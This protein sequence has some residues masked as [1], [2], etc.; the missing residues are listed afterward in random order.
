MPR[1]ARDTAAF[2]LIELMIV[3]AILG[4]LASVAIPSFNSYTRR[5]RTAE[6]IQNL[7][8]MYRTASALYVAERGARGVTASVV[9]ACVV[10]S[11]NLTPPSPGPS[12]QKFISTPGF[13][14]LG[15]TFGDYIYYGYGITSIGN[16]GGMTCFAGGQ[17]SNDVYTFFAQGDLD[18]NGTRSTFQLAISVTDGKQLVHSHGVYLVNELE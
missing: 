8:A 10:E 2:T 18:G 6:P 17:I 4:I 11:S 1:G 12:K 3:V 5:S 13:A 7:N 15:Y 14:E 16:A 9:T